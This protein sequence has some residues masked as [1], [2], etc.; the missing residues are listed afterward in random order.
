MASCHPWRSRCSALPR[1][2]G[3]FSGTPAT[4][5]TLFVA[6]GLPKVLGEIDLSSP[7]CRNEAI[8]AAA[9]SL[10]PAGVSASGDPS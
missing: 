2:R 7:R 10:S 6:V 3:A 9:C 5:A 8:G 4:P 1:F